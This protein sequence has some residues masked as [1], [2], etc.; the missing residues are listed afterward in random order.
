MD[1]KTANLACSILCT[2]G[3]LCLT[4]LVIIRQVNTL[5]LVFAGAGIFL[6]ALGLAIKALYFR[7]PNCGRR[8]PMKSDGR[9]CPY[10]NKK[11]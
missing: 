2:V 8:L 10:C 1:Y 5:F 4:C 9:Y 3:L 6:L 11:L 7:C